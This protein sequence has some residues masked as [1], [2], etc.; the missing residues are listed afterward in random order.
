MV[1]WIDMCSADLPGKGKMMTI[2]RGK[3]PHIRVTYLYSGL[4]SEEG[5][6]TI[7]HLEYSS[8]AILRQISDLEDLKI[9]RNGA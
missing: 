6:P 9:R 7:T 4:E 5:I 3:R 2:F 1:S 8:K